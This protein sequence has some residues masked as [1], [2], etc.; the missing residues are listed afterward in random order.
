MDLTLALFVALGG[1]AGSVSR[2]ALSYLVQS[3]ASSTFPVATL[4]VNVSGSLLLGFLVRYAMETQVISAEMRLML[5]T[6]FCGGYTTFSTFSFELARLVEDGDYRRASG[7][8]A[9]SVVLSLLGTFAG[10]A[11]A[12]GLVAAQRGST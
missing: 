6:G 2:Y 8:A 3:R 11:L 4:I 10:F 9:L 7:Y 5:T 1:A 12:R